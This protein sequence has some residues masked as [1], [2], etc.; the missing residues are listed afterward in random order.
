V[1]L[2]Q[3]ALRE[4]ET[5][6]LRISPMVLFEMQ[7]LQDIGRLNAPPQEFLTILRRDFDVAVCSLAFPEVVEASYR[8]AWTRDPFDRL[9][10]A[11]AR[12]QGGKL[13][14]KDRLIR[15]NF[16]DAVW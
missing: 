5:A 6:Q 13:I 9:I 12:A 4:I 3:P 8:E 11:Q 1:P 15:Q 2:S 16:P 7:L 10:T 14:T